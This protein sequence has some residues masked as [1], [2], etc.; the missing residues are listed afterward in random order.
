MN[1]AGDFLHY[2]GFLVVAPFDRFLGCR[3]PLGTHIRLLLCRLDKLRQPC[4]SLR[5]RTYENVVL[6]LLT[7]DFAFV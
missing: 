3:H 4:R 6:R 2:V 7:L 5:F 1:A